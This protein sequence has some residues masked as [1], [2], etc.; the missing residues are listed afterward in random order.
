[1]EIVLVGLNHR[2]APVEV[3][4][5]VSFT[6]AQARLA[7]RELRA[8]GVFH[9]TLVLS[10]CNRSELY[11]VP[12][13][14]YRESAAELADYL[15]SFHSVGRADLDGSLYRRYDRHAVR[16]L[17]RVASGLDS[18]VLGEAE[19]LGQ[20]REAYRLA[21]QSGATGPVLNR[22]FQGALEVGKRVRHETELSTRPMS[23]ASEGVKLA[24]RIFGKLRQ[25]AALVL[26]AGT[27]SE[28]V[29][30]QLRDRDIAHL[31]VMNRSRDRAELLAR[32]FSG[33][34]IDWEEWDTALALPYFINDTASTE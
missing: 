14:T 7:A 4:E 9:E 20:V 16:H 25:R 12:R 18:M 28:Q 29:V 19:I 3:R 17:Y 21:H 23:V 34:V 11:A 2:S 22:M 13:E 31:Y 6:A 33:K 10:T 32:E 27:I 1:M 8:G 30:A 24:E 5:R 15:S 26:G